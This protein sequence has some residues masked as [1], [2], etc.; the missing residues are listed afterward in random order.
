MT[1]DIYSLIYHKLDRVTGGLD[2]FMRSKG[3]KKLKA[4]GFMDL[5][6]EKIGKDTISLTHY[7]E[8]M[9]DLIPD[10]DITVKIYPD[11]KMAEALTY[12]DGLRY[13]EV[14][15]E[16]NKVNLKIKKSLN[17]FL[18]QWLIVLNKQGFYK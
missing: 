11:K 10:P 6:I 17:T 15:P 5:V 2:K 4:S 8:C 12:Q 9:G 14:Y 1:R 18:N 7:Y 3:Y 16:E 13:Q